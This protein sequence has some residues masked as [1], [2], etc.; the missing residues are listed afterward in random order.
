MKKKAHWEIWGHAYTCSECK[1]CGD[2]PSNYCRMC[3]AEMS[4]Q[5]VYVTPTINLPKLTFSICSNC[6]RQII[7]VANFCPD[8]G[9][10]L[11]GV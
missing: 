7:G 3:G 10:K 1:H 6:N 11:D 4:E 5:S 2:E 8:C 9:E